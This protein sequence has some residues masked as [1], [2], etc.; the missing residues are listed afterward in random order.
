[1]KLNILF[2]KCF[3]DCMH[4]RVLFKSQI[5][6]EFNNWTARY[7]YGNYSQTTLQEYGQSRE[8]MFIQQ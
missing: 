5:N 2:K 1:M 7:S 3:S 8:V 6:A 4:F